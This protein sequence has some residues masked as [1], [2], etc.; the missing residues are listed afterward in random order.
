MASLALV[1]SEPLVSLASLVSLNKDSNRR[2]FCQL[3]SLRLVF[4]NG[5]SLRPA[6]RYTLEW[7]TIPKPLTPNAVHRTVCS[8]SHIT[9]LSQCTP[10]RRIKSRTCGH[11]QNH[12]NHPCDHQ[13]RKSCRPK[14]VAHQQRLVPILVAGLSCINLCHTA[15]RCD[16]PSGPRS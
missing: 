7:S 12:R 2:S 1:P 3:Q 16:Q 14:S 8:G 5:G 10:H 15:T 11:S 13:R 9:L 4:P 6:E